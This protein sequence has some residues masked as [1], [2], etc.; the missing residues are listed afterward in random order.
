ML[1]EKNIGKNYDEYD[2][3]GG[4]YRC[5][6]NFKCLNEKGGL[7]SI[8][9]IEKNLI[10]IQGEVQNW[11]DPKDK[12]PVFL[13]NISEYCLDSG[14]NG[15]RYKGVWVKTEKG[16]YYL[17]NKPSKDYEPVYHQFSRK[18]EIWI[19]IW[20]LML[21]EIKFKKLSTEEVVD[22]LKKNQIDLEEIKKYKEFF[23]KRIALDFK[24]VQKQHDFVKKYILTTKRKVKEK[25]EE[26]SSSEDEEFEISKGSKKKREKKTPKKKQAKLELEINDLIEIPK[27]LLSKY[28][29][30]TY[31]NQG[32]DFVI[33]DFQDGYICTECIK[34]KGF[35]YSEISEKSWICP[36]CTSKRRIK[37]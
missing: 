31:C 21:D 12:V 4:P 8:E 19:V 15:G 22:Q 16:V 33:C 27:D 14:S 23:W 30:C 13:R 2:D 37:K 17:L 29:K 1:E 32:R 18:V 25:V 34:R 9:D 10:T 11:N 35:I 5:L 3:N 28:P 36:I 26:E 6:T 7:I 24:G 20:N